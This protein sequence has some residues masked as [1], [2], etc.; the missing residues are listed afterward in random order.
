MTISTI[1]QVVAAVQDIALTITGVRMA[2][3]HFPDKIETGPQV[4]T[5]PGPG[6]FGTMGAG[7]WVE[8]HTITSDILVSGGSYAQVRKAGLSIVVPFCRALIAAPTLG[9]TVQ[10]FAGINYQFVEEFALW[11]V[12]ITGVKILS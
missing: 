1:E 10:T 6:D 3:D 9:G 8:L 5:Y 4:V 2:P 11:R 12:Q 7:Y